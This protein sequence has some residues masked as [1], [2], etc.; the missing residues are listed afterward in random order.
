[1]PKFEA[2]LVARYQKPEDDVQRGT[3]ATIWKMRETANLRRFKAGEWETDTFWRTPEIF[4]K[5]Q[6]ETPNTGQRPGG[7]NKLSDPSIRPEGS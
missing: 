5:A 4:I 7:R 1:M 2:P 3:E 6:N